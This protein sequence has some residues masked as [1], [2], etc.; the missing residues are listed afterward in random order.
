VNRFRFRFATVLRY[1]EM[2]EDG[3]KRR[4][5]EALG[6]LR[7]EEM[8]LDGIERERT[9]HDVVRADHADTGPVYARRLEDDHRYARWLDMKRRKQ[10]HRVKT[11]AD[12]VA[13]R[14]AELVEAT[15]HKKIFTRLEERDR[16]AWMAEARLEEQAMNDEVATTRYRRGGR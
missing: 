14:R 6:A 1:R 7:I 2:I 10:S 9:T 11:A 4:M 5:G 15:K 13:G 12:F 16:D 3:H 8:A